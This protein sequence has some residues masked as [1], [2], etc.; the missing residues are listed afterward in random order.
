MRT[1]NTA[2]RTQQLAKHS[3]AW[4]EVLSPLVL[5]LLGGA[6]SILGRTL[7]VDRVKCFPV[8]GVMFLYCFAIV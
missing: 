1:M 7:L 3:R 8:P 6:D 5:W 2:G 4:P